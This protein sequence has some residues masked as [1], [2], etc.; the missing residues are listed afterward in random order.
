MQ[1]RRPKLAPNKSAR[2]L[3][4]DANFLKLQKWKKDFEARNGREATKADLMLADAE[5]KA[6]AARMGGL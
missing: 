6:I 5:I 2:E 4:I 1:S 3:H